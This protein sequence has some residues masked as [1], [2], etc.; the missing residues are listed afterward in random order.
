M[1]ENLKF[2]AFMEQAE[3]AGISH[4]STI[5]ALTEQFLGYADLT[6]VEWEGGAKSYGALYEDIALTRGWLAENGFQKGDRVALL[7]MNEYEFVRIFYA[8][9]T[10]GMVAV[11]LMPNLPPTLFPQLFLKTQLRAVMYDS[12]FTPLADKLKPAI[13]SIRFLGTGEVGR[14]EPLPADAVLS[15]DDPAVI[16]YTSG[17]TGRPKGAV[18]SHRAL[19]RGAFNGCFGY[20]GVFEQRY[21]ALI[22]FAH[23]FGLVRCLL[24]A[25]L[26]RSLLYLCLDMKAFI[27][28]LK[29][30]QPTILVLVP[31]LAD[32]LYSV[33]MG[34]GWQTLGGRLRLIIAGGAPVGQA[35]IE[36]FAAQGVM[37]APGYGLTETANLVSGN[38]QPLNKPGSVGLIYD[39]QSYRIEDGELWLKGDNLMSGYY[40][41]P[42][43]TAAALCDGWFRTGDLA[44]VDEDGYLYITGRLKNLIILGNGENVSPE[45]L[46]ER[47]NALPFVKDSLVKE[48]K[49]E[50]GVPVIGVEIFAD[51]R[52]VQSLGIT[53]VKAAAE[54]GITAINREL[55][56]YMHIAKVTIVEHDFLRGGIKKLR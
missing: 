25:H 52:A 46:E 48:D 43:E 12:L 26:T 15:A 13:P 8:L 16:L 30:A 32:M 42:E 3:L 5:A 18:L 19:L 33:G 1:Q 6:A 44:R 53:D 34:Y 45:A 39:G 40:N 24:T 36:R 9:T 17:T 20:K 38:P 2:Q 28:D 41:D 47:V 14:G 7:M 55:P 56:P 54:Q 37:V 31:A 11:P 49:N 27:R 35:L 10:S 21:Y 23:V 22:P 51:D 4:P 50:H 29:A